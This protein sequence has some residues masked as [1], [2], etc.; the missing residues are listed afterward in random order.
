MVALSFGLEFHHHK[1]GNTHDDCP[2]C[3]ALHLAQASSLNSRPAGRP[4]PLGIAEFTP[5]PGKEL[6]ASTLILVP[7][8][9]PPPTF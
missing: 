4:V 5:L 1:D 9:R 3:V 8:I 6:V 2:L 7:V